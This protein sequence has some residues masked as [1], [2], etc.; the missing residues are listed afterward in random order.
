M[1]LPYPEFELLENFREGEVI[2]PSPPSSL[3]SSTSS[4]RGQSSSILFGRV[5][6]GL[7]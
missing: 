3:K 1:A 5:A 6:R 2:N 4:F 7:E